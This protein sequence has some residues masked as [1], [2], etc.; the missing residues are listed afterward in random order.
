MQESRREIGLVYLRAVLEKTGL[1][2]TELAR[3]VGVS[4]TTITRPLHDVNHKYALSLQTLW[5]IEEA[6]KVPLPPELR[7][8][9]GKP[10]E[11]VPTGQGPA[12]R[13]LKLLGQGAGNNGM[14]VEL[15]DHLATSYVERPWFLLGRPDAYAIYV[16]DSSMSPAFEHGHLVYVDPTR[17]VSAG[18]DVVIQTDQDRAFIKRLVRRTASEVACKQF[19]PAKTVRFKPEN[20][21]A[22][23]KIIAS[24]RT[25]T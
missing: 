1:T 25:P 3:K 11:A 23:H 9:T 24:L 17:P 19:N 2:P 7:R 8:G 12:V 20:I 21:K 10:V 4:Q 16:Y 14:G 22:I 13:D 18:D 6:F 15:R 5:S